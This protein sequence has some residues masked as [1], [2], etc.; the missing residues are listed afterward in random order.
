VLRN[1]VHEG[2]DRLSFDAV[3]LY[4]WAIGRSTDGDPLSRT[5]VSEYHD[6]ARE[7]IDAA[8][9]TV[10]RTGPPPYPD[11]LLEE[12]SMLW[13]EA[14]VAER[15]A[16]RLGPE[17]SYSDALERLLDET[18][19]AVSLET[20]IGTYREQSDARFVGVQT[21]RPG[22]DRELPLS[23][24][25]PEPGETPLPVVESEAVLVGDEPYPFSV[26][27]RPVD[28]GTGSL[29]TLFADTD[30]EQVSVEAGIE[31]LQRALAGVEASLPEAV[32]HAREAGVRGL[33]VGDEPVGTGVHLLWI[34]PGETE[35]GSFVSP[36]RLILDDR[37]LTVGRVTTLSAAEY[38]D[39][40]GT[41]LLWAAPEAG[42]DG[43]VELPEDP[44]ERRERFPNAVL[45][46]G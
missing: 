7:K 3:G 10:K 20:L 18:L 29:L 27:E 6:R 16:R 45:R 12:P 31:R 21:V 28:A 44:V 4:V 43:T 1:L 33:A 36:D 24:H 34:L 2:A 37:T 40:E 15:L 41:T 30:D 5:I 9:A 42:L 22:W 26:A 46:T 35:A 32:E 17:E 39:E 14:G 8:E 13:V 38:E 19:D 11:D 25:V 23:I